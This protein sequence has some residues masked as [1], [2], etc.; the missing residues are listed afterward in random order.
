MSVKTSDPAEYL[1]DIVHTNGVACSTV[2]DGHVLVF[3]R[4]K[5]LQILDQTGD[6]EIL[7]IFIQ[8]P[9]MKA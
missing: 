1:L 4:E 7:T 8:R 5:L 9:D 6:S 2:K 3:K